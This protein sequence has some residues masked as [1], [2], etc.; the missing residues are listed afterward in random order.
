[1]AQHGVEELVVQLDKAMDLSAVVPGIRL[2]GSVLADK[3]LN[4]WG[5]RNILRAAWKSYGKIEI[6]WV[7]DNTFIITVPDENVAGQ[8]LD[9]VSWGVMKK[10]FLVNVWPAVLA[11]KE[12]EIEKVPFWVQI[13]RVPLFLTSIENVKRLT[14]EVGT[15]LAMEDPVKARGF[16]RVRLLIDSTKP[17]VSGCWLRRESNRDTWV[18]FCYERLQDFCYRCGC[19]RHINTDCTFEA[20]KA[21]AAGFGEWLKA[22]PVRDVVEV[23]K[24][25]MTGTSDRRR[26]GATRVP[27]TYLRSQGITELEHTSES[28]AVSENERGEM[29]FQGEGSAHHSNVR[30][31]WQRRSRAQRHIEETLGTNNQLNWLIP[32]GIKQ[33]L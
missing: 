1:M 27:A 23:P 25:M 14:R 9:Q 26:A 33:S 12:V 30:K 24:V 22:P 17:L 10:N 2:V 28:S 3:P 11:L 20:T 16:L 6:K 4:R 7:S 21:G 29:P 19:L 18:E 13:R 31:K 5:V 8:I 32:Q 15:Y